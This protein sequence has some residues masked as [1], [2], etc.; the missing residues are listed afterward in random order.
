MSR[1][2]SRG[3]DKRADDL[4][5][6]KSQE[7]R[8]YRSEAPAQRSKSWKHESVG[9]RPLTLRFVSDDPECVTVGVAVRPEEGNLSRSPP[10]LEPR[11][12]RHHAESYLPRLRFMCNAVAV[13][14][15]IQLII[16]GA[17]RAS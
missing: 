17:P 12:R 4:D 3:H 14:S 5:E 15:I 10:R 8:S 2:Q 7:L 9:M 1:S 11:F 6:R 13:A 16:D